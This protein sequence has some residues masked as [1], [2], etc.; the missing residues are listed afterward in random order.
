M[1]FFEEP[2]TSHHTCTEKSALWCSEVD[3]PNGLGPARPHDKKCAATRTS[4]PVGPKMDSDQAAF[5]FFPLKNVIK[6]GSVQMPTKERTQAINRSQLLMVS[7]AIIGTFICRDRE[8]GIFAS[9]ALVF[10]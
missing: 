10:F 3:I 5:A 7:S 6:C 1:H 8:H 2:R 9:L 4:G